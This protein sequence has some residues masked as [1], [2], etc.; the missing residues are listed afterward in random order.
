MAG[1]E[2]PGDL[3]PEQFEKGLS[4]QTASRAKKAEA[5]KARTELELK[6]EGLRSGYVERDPVS[7]NNR[8]FPG[9]Q[10]L[11]IQYDEGGNPYIAR[12]EGYA[13]KDVPKGVGG[14]LAQR[15][16]VQQTAYVDS[17]DG[18]PLFF[19]REG[20]RYVR[21]SDGQTV[22]GRPVPNKGQGEAVQSAARA[23][24]LMPKIDVL[25][26]ALNQKSELG[27]RAAV[28]PAIGPAFYPEI[29]QLRQEVKQVGFTFGGKNFTGNEEAII[30]GALIP[31]PFDSPASRE[32][33]RTA[34]KGYVSGQIDLMGAANLLGPAGIEIKRVI[35][36]QLKAITTETPAQ[37]KQRLLNELSGAK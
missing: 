36:P 13:P 15:G 4:L 27:A 14:G 22:V 8:T 30:M 28:A 5:A 23:S 18:A 10:G 37:R 17:S 2:V 25:F 33:K 20:Q 26:D 35:K 7:G 29:N 9:V 1:E 34:L 6:L 31:G 16:S 19:D 24:E 3:T 21:S 11:S 12:D 32:A